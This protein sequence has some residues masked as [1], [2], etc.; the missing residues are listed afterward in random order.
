MAVLDQETNPATASH[1]GH[2][3]LAAIEGPTAYRRLG[4]GRQGCGIATVTLSHGIEGASTQ[5]IPQLNPGVDVS[6]H[7][8]G[9]NPYFEPANK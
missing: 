3:E 5:A 8:S 4:A 2:A 1:G 7:A 9:T 6:D